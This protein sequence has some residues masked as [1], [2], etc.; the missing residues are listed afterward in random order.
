MSAIQLVGSMMPLAAIPSRTDDAAP[1]RPAYVDRADITAAA[2][3]GPAPFEPM[4]PQGDPPPDVHVLWGVKGHSMVNGEAARSMPEDMP[5]FFREAHDSL[6]LLASQPDRWKFESLQRLSVVNR[7]DHWINSELLK[8]NPL[9]NDRYAYLGLII[10]D[11]LNHED[12]PPASV[13]FL[14][15]AISETFEK[16]EAEMALWRRETDGS[17]ADSPLAKQLEKNV[18]YTAGLLGH[19]AGDAAQPL[20]TTAHGDGWDESVES[21]PDGFSTKRGIHSRFE[22]QFV[23]RVSFDS[24]Q[25]FMHPA[26]ALDGDSLDIARDFVQQ[27]HGH[28]HE[29]YALDK[30]GKLNPDSPSPEGVQFTVQRLAAGAQLLRDLWYTAWIRSEALAQQAQGPEIDTWQ[31]AQTS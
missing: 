19:Y 12:R 10:N 29:L 21:N 11:H 17:G 20:H 8:G 1:V 6:T 2:A 16:L 24:L 23:N 5:K 31:M 15:Y 18:I 9:P 4:P 30:E 13:G 7:P 22:T 26:Q 14:P 28:V 25:K 3:A 27:S